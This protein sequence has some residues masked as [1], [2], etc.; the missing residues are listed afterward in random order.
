MGI[1]HCTKKIM[2]LEKRRLNV[3]E[4][5]ADAA[6]FL[7]FYAD[8]AEALKLH[9]LAL[10]GLEYVGF[11]NSCKGFAAGHQDAH[12]NMLVRHPVYLWGRLDF[13]SCDFGG[14]AQLHVAE[15]LQPYFQ[16]LVLFVVVFLYV[17][18]VAN[19]DDPP[20]LAGRV[21]L[22]FNHFFLAVLQGY[23]LGLRNEEITLCLGIYYLPVVSC[24][25]LERYRYV[26]RP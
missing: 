12:D 13:I 11:P 9:D 19:G 26:V 24:K 1:S 6:L 8:E 7:A 17:N 3:R 4:K 2:A 23:H 18:P 20:L 25:V 15:I 22:R 21:R 16:P 5:S 10:L 14:V